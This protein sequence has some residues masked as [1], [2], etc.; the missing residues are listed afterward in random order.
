MVGV[1]GAHWHMKSKVHDPINHPS[2]YTAHPSGVECV[3]VAEH[4]N[5]NVGNAIK[6]LWRA[7]LKGDALE[8]LK[9]AAWYVSREVQRLTFQQA[10]VGLQQ[11]PD[12]GYKCGWDG[13]PCDRIFWGI[14]TP[15]DPDIEQVKV[16]F[17]SRQCLAN[18]YGIGKVKDLAEGT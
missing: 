15:T 3:E 5:F 17:C 2:H 12:G 10:P 4:F 6:Y 18:W 7:G 8:D 13:K 1:L 9:K 11:L 14:T 16:P